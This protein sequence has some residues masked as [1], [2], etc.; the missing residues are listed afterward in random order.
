MDEAGKPFSK[1]PSGTNARKLMFFLNLAKKYRLGEFAVIGANRG[2]LTGLREGT[3]QAADGFWASEK[4]VRTAVAS[5]GFSRL[6]KS[7]FVGIGDIWKNSSEQTVS[8]DLW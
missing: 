3:G 6:E 2:N 7:G 8:A 5:G 4:R 1:L